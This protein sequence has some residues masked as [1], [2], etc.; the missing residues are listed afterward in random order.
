M[1]ITG[2]SEL[3]ALNRPHFVRDHL[4]WPSAVRYPCNEHEKV[5]ITTFMATFMIRLT[6]FLYFN[7]LLGP[8][9]YLEYFDIKPTNLPRIFM[10]YFFAEQLTIEKFV[11]LLCD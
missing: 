9:N 10:G 7:F 1:L 2:I 11:I 4:I 3:Q 6:F 8:N 5:I